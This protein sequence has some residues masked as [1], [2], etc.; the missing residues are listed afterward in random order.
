MDFL[1]AAPNASLKYPYALPPL[2][3]DYGA[4]QSAVDEQTM[5]VHHDKH[6]QGY[7]DKFN[8]ALKDQAE[9]QQKTL[10]ELLSD[11]STLPDDVR[12]AVRNNGGGYFN[13]ALFW[14][15]LSENGGGDPGG[16]LGKAIERDFGSFSA[17]KEQFTN[18]ATTLF[19]S[20]WA[21]LVKNSGGKLEV[22]KTA[23]QDTPLMSSK[24][25]VLGIDVWEHAYYLKY[26]NRRAEYVG[27]FWKIVNWETCGRNY[28]E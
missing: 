21:W 5:R 18:A 20:G 14:P 1:N 9:L 26:Q 15:M 28:D 4:L 11:L 22:I 13:H 16:E 3:Y 10:V 27:N 2:P 25:P 12:V 23:N 7:T 8:K 17:F 24:T 19:G 6:H